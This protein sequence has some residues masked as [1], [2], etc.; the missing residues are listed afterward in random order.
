MDGL[1]E[2]TKTQIW[3][4]INELSSANKNNKNV[5]IQVSL[6]EYGKST[7]SVNENY[8]R[9]LVPLTNDLDDLSEKLFNLKTNGRGEF[10][11]AVILSSI[12]RLNWS[13]HKDNLKLI[14]ISGNESFN[15][16][17]VDYKFA[18]KKATDNNII[19]NTIFCG[20]FNTGVNFQWKTAAD[21]GNGKY[22]NIS[23]NDTVKIYNTKYDNKINILGNKL[24]DTYIS[25]NKKSEM[26]ILNKK[27]KI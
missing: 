19:V 21:I 26:R 1:I 10:A 23:Q 3:K 17:N 2:Q 4:I 16:G 27:N 22:M 25:Y 7:I 9:M 15:Q 5:T 14:L 24:N 20:D 6:F 13:N 12:N 8:L 11:G 18:I